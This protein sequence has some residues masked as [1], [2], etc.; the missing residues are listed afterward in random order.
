MANINVDSLKPDELYD[1]AYFS[2]AEYADYLRDR[3]V[4]ERNFNARL[5]EVRRF[6]TNGKLI[7]VGCAYGY[8]LNL[9]RRYFSVRGFDIAESALEHARN[10]FGLPVDNAEFVDANI[11]PN[12]VDVVVMWDTIEHLLRPDLVVEKAADSLKQGGSLFLTTGDIGSILA[13]IRGKNWRLIH[14]PSH[15]HYFNKDTIRRFLEGFGF[16]IS[17]IKYVPVWRSLRQI[18]Y[19]LLF[20]GKDDIPRIY[21]LIENSR[22]GP[23]PL[24]LNTLDIML[25]GG[26][27][28][29]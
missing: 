6:H 23:L 15:L 26:K 16:E 28:V 21:R 22:I 8:F 25:V 11:E 20:I 10:V 18:L 14:P 27:K 3:D 19:S 5:K 4:L 1:E 13:R 9:A 29:R 2:G 24:P 7:E 12:S 17:V